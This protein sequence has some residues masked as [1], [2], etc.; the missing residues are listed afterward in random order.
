MPPVEPVSPLDFALH[1]LNFFLPA[2]VVGALLAALA[3]WLVRGAR[4]R[5]GWPLQAALNALAG[6][7]ALAAG[8][9]YFGNDGKMAT[10]AALVLACASTQWVFMHGA[11]PRKRG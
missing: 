4:S 3:P 11:G 10:Y 2:W 9:W 8:L 5:H 6:S 7:L 1:L